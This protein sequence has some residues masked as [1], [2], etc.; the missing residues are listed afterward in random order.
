[1]SAQFM[2]CCTIDACN[3]DDITTGCVRLDA[4]GVPELLLFDVV[5]GV[6][7]GS[8]ESESDGSVGN[9]PWDGVLFGVPQADAEP[10]VAGVFEGESGEGNGCDVGEVSDILEE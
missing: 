7:G 9:D 3:I 5:A 6:D 10:M 8:G 2:P 1:M 4:V